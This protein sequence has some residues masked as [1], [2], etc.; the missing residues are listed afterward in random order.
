TTSHS[1][2]GSSLF[3]SSVEA[4]S[5]TSASS[6]SCSSSS[7]RTNSPEESDSKQT[8]AE[9]AGFRSS[10]VSSVIRAVEI[11]NS[12]SR[13]GSWSFLRPERTSL[14]PTVLRDGPAHLLGDLLERGEALLERRVI[15]EQLGDAALHLGGDDEEGV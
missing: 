8:P 14:R 9:P 1:S 4:V 7:A 3:R 11:A 12:R 6:I 2:P 10:P 15:H 13:A 5:G